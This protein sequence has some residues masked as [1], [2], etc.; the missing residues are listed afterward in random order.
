MN[1][2]GSHPNPE[3]RQMFIST[4]LIHRGGAPWGA[5]AFSFPGAWGSQP[6]SVILKEANFQGKSYNNLTLSGALLMLEEL[7]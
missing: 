5:A 4:V 3:N 2:S 6:P 1:I 7:S